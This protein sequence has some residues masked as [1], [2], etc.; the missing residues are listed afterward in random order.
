[1]RVAV[2]IPAGHP[3]SPDGPAVVAYRLGRVRDGI[4][5]HLIHT[6]ETVPMDEFLVGLSKQAEAEYPDCE[7]KVEHLV[8]NGDGTATWVPA[9]EFDPEA[10]TPA[11]EGEA[12]ATEVTV[13]AEVG[14]P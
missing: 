3:D 2:H 4:D 12:K 11:G 9:D 1:M 5:N 8:D 14:T 7:I 6:G 13:Q 10:H